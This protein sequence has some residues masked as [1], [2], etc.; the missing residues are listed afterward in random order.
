MEENLDK[1]SCAFCRTKIY[2]QTCVKC[3]Q[4]FR[5]WVFKSIVFTNDNIMNKG[6]M[7][8]A[9]G[10]ILNVCG[11]AEYNHIKRRTPIKQWPGFYCGNGKWK[12]PDVRVTCSEEI[13]IYNGVTILRKLLEENGIYLYN[14]IQI[15]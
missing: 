4:G 11:D 10:N 8:L 3:I 1:R 15:E 12:I 2:N 6:M 7:L 5:D 14:N 13:N 9:I